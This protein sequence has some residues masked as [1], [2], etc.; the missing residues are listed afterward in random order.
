MQREAQTN[1]DRDSTRQG[2][3][4]GEIGAGREQREQRADSGVTVFVG[5]QPYILQEVIQT[6]CWPL[7]YLFETV[8]Q[9]SIL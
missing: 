8:S 7:L 2:A 4:A 6:F 5:E 1:L 3:E 9:A